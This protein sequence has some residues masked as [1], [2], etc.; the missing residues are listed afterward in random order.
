MNMQAEGMMTVTGGTNNLVQNLE[1]HSETRA[2]HT[3][4]Y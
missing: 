3:F 2:L 4:W 1:N